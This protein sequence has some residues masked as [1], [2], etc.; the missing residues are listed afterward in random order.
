MQGTFNLLQPKVGKTLEDVFPV[1]YSGHKTAY[2]VFIA[3]IIASLIISV[4]DKFEGETERGTK[5][6]KKVENISTRNQFLE[7][8]IFVSRYGTLQGKITGVTMALH[9]MGE[10][11]NVSNERR[12]E[13]L[14]EANEMLAESI[15]EIERLRVVP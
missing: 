9:L 1:S 5:L 15:N 12:S 11:K 10:M 2:G 7:D 13:L 4:Q 14:T 6:S 3:S 8:S